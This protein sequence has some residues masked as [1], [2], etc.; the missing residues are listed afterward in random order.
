[1]AFDTLNFILFF[2]I[3]FILYWKIFSKS[4]N[5]Q[6]TYLLVISFLFYSFWDLRFTILLA[7][8]I[9][10]GYFC[11]KILANTNNLLKRKIIFNA[12]IL[13]LLSFLLI[14]KYYNFFIQNFVDLFS[15]LGLNIDGFYLNIILPVGISFYTFHGVS[16][17]HDLYYKK[18]DQET[19]IVNYGVF[20]SYFPL[21]VAGPIERASTLLPQL[22]KKRFF[23]YNFSV[24]G[25]RLIL[26]GMFK[27]VVIADPLS[28]FNDT[29]FLNYNSLDFTILIL[30]AI[31]FSVQVYADFSGY[32]DMARGI[33]RLMGIELIKNF[34]FPFFS[35][36]IPEFWSRWHISLSSW[37]NDYIFKP[38][39]VYFRDYRKYGILIAIFITFF[40]S[41][42]WHGASWNF[43]VWG[44]LYAFLY[45][46]Y[47]FFFKKSFIINTNNSSLSLKD[48]ANIFIIFIMVCI[49]FVFFRLQNISDAFEYLERIFTLAKL[50]SEYIFYNSQK[51]LLSAHVSL[52]IFIDYCLFSSNYIY[53]LTIRSSLFR[54][55]IYSIMLCLIL[56]YFNRTGAQFIYFQF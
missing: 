53:K 48:L 10:I 14:F 16:Y 28:V 18:I 9:L 36:S 38:C 32:T 30:G 11:G 45:I 27:K 51:I 52:I 22:K 42:L 13:S 50:E 31:G 23:N 1:M 15:F 54:Y 25:L 29:I 5:F 43:I 17:L 21:L 39:A 7:L 4:N 56:I 37:M 55:L 6:N 49:A 26:L 46:P 20:I 41:G 34:N 24:S 44:L 8:N 35:K 19:S 12:G 33:S 2:I 3:N 40:I 47:L